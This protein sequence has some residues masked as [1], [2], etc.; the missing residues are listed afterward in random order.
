MAFYAIDIRYRRFPGEPRG[1]KQPC[2]M[3]YKDGLA[4][5]DGAVISAF[6]R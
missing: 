2:T 6:G 3:R 5:F 4:N 1:H